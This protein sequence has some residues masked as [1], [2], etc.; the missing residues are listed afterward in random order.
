M[1][2][3]ILGGAESLLDL[4][5]AIRF[6][7]RSAQHG[8]LQRQVDAFAC[9]DLEDGRAFAV[10]N[11]HG[12]WSAE[13]KPPGSSRGHNPG[14]DLVH[15]GGDE[16]VFGPRAEAHFKRYLAA[17]TGD[18]AQYRVRRPLA[19]PVG[20]LG[21]A[22]LHSVRQNSRAS[23]RADRGLEHHAGIDVGPVPSGAAPGLE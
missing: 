15:Q 2:P 9:G 18:A 19:Q 5:L 10:S 1:P 11:G 8:V 23:L 6:W 14:A 4:T 7:Q 13:E 16:A 22:D 12:S 21:V 3:G 20:V 17:G